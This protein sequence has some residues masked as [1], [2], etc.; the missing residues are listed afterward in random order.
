VAIDRLEV[1]VDGPLGDVP[2]EIL[3][4]LRGVLRRAEVRQVGHLHTARHVV[5][6][7]DG[8]GRR[9]G[10]VS[11][12]EVSV[13]EAG[14]VAARFREVEVEVVSGA[15]GVLLPA[16][17]EH[18]RAA[19]AGEPDPTPKLVRALGPRALAQADPL[20]PPLGERPSAATAIQAAIA[21]SVQRLLAHDPIVRLD[22]GMV[23]V[24]QARVS[25]RRLRSDLRTF[26]P[27]LDRAWAEGLR[28][29]LAWLAGSLGQVRDADVLGARLRR[30]AEQL[31]R[32]DAQQAL[33]LLRRLDRERVGHLRALHT[34]LDSDRYFDLLDALVDAAKNPRLLRAASAPAREVLPALAAGPWRKLRKEARQLG[35]GATDEELHFL[36]IRTKRARYA[37][38]AVARAV[39]EAAA[40]GE[41]LAELQGILGEQ[42]DAV[43]AED[44]IRGAVAAGSSRQQALAAGLLIAL[45]RAEAASH[46]GAW[47]EAWAAADRRKVRAWIPT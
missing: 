44:W 39:P 35:S 19:G 37:A 21:S 38:E 14:R 3:S 24:H 13:L 4:I 23:G 36:R 9:L 45:Q 26:E 29:E 22:A 34:D 33:R 8:G 18:L 47:R 2:Q 43:V 5:T 25:T 41:A 1:E 46:R 17:V 11:D 32:A 40:T 30:D 15:P 10:E 16:L 28:T 20:V 31:G 7:R 12:D 42:H 27:L 6:L